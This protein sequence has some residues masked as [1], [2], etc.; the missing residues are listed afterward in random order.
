VALLLSACQK[1]A[2]QQETPKDKGTANPGMADMPDMPGMP[3][4]SS[5]KPSS[6]EGAETSPFTI[7]PERLQ[8]IGVRTG[9]VQ[10]T[11]LQRLLRVPGIVVV[12]E[13]SLW[14]INVKAA[15]GYI[16]E[17][18][19]NYTGKLVHKGEPL[20]TILSE[21]WMEAQEDYMKAYLAYKRT[22]LMSPNENTFYLEQK[23]ERYRARIRVWDLS[24]D[25]IHQL[26][27][28]SL[29][30]TDIELSEHETK[31]LRGTFDLLSPIDGIVVE[32]Q[33]IQGMQ[34]ET[35]QSLFRLAKLSPIWV[36]AEFPEDQA[37]YVGLGHEF[38]IT[39]PAQPELNTKAKV[40]F[41]YPQL[42]PDTRRLKA[43]FILQ[44][45]NLKIL[46]GMFANVSC[47][48]EEGEKLAVPVDA[49]I[50]TGE[51]FVVFLDHGQGKL[52]PR[53]VKLGDRL[54]D[55]YEVL[56][57]LSEGDHVVTSANFLIDSESRLQG[58]LKLWSDTGDAPTSQ[59]SA[60]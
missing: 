12:D 4:V 15:S 26:E 40:D 36:E 54:G 56:D 27:E 39:F 7:S 20:A 8:E 47:A 59:Q 42:K 29:R 18:Q 55:S 10:K 34:Y 1:P 24:E 45:A 41:I 48:F 49:V 9:V 2:S 23:L 44:N 28:L 57:G 13:S 30:T 5:P 21:G 16:E 50:P 37:P 52:E 11:R 22:V 3:A 19:A 17:L 53:F 51:R 35:G 43:R 46:P 14:D 60:P 58:A 6:Q 25:Q 31:G 32:K 38:N 33:A